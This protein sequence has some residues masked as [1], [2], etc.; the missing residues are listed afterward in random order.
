MTTEREALSV[1]LI[2]NYP[3]T[4]ELMSYRL[5]ENFEREHNLEFRFPLSNSIEADVLIVFNE[6]KEPVSARYRKGFL[7][8][9]IQEP[10]VSRR[11]FHFVRR[12]NKRYNR[13]Y[14]HYLRTRFDDPS[15]FFLSP[16]LN[17]WWLEK[18]FTELVNQ[19]PSRKSSLISAIAST[20]RLFP[21]HRV[22]DDFFERLIIERPEVQV[23]GA[24][25]KHPLTKKS[26][27]IV[28]FRFSIAIENSSTPDYWTEKI[29]DCFL[30]WTIP[31]YFGAP[32]I[33]DYFPKDSFIWLPLTNPSLA[34]STIEDVITTGGDWQR[35][36]PALTEAR[37]LCLG[38]YNLGFRISTL[39]DEVRD[40]IA[41]T[42]FLEEKLR[43]DAGILHR[44]Y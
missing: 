36:L 19:S 8:N 7:W 16:P 17:P 43:P 23:F 26:D 13:V 4:K 32:N 38:S 25:R 21:T 14:S 6:L 2:G 18:S 35:R 29:V 40:E 20:K 37:N 9:W 3:I 42:P 28:P 22:R 24:G 11:G 30:G 5:P 33:G 44:F 15:R 41:G 27:G 31:I 39:L 1:G 34:M 10:L 12:P